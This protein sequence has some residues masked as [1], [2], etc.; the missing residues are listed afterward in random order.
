MKNKSPLNKA[1]IPAGAAGG[2]TFPSHGVGEGAAS[3]FIL[4]AGALWGSMGLFVRTLGAAGLDSAGIAQLRCIVTTLILSVFLLI[5]DRSFFRIRL[6]DVWCFAGTGVLSIVFFNLCYFE[7][8]RRTSLSVA[9]VLLYT[10]PAFVILLSA[11]FFREKITPR[12]IL[13]LILTFLGCICVSGILR[14]GFSLTPSGFLTGIGA[15]IGYALYSIFSRFALEKGYRSMTISFYT[16]LFAVFGTL[17]FV[18][19]KSIAGVMTSGISM[20]AFIFVFGTVTTVFPYILYTKGLEGVENGRAS[21]LASV[22]PVVATLLGIL[23]FR[24]LLHM[25][26]IAGILLVLGAIAISSSSGGS[27][28]SSSRSSNVGSS[29]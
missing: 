18:S 15:G 14:G 10:A 22:E 11:L 4:T 5:R 1:D 13:S 12:K 9:A 24:E 21:I 26:E 27:G 7:T 8:I 20:T 23:V 16:F 17:P 28:S 6:R 2:G 19:I 3:V 29:S 25:D